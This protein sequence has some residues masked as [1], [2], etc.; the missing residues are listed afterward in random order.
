MICTSHDNWHGIAGYHS[1][2]NKTTQS[3]DFGVY[4]IMYADHVSSTGHFSV[5][6]DFTFANRTQTSVI[7]GFS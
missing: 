1:G 3:P 2:N 4:D 7:N 5:H 6:N